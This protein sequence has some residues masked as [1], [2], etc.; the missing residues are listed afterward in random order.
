MM[1]KWS[2]LFILSI[3]V[4]GVTFT[5]TFFAVGFGVHTHTEK[6]ANISEIAFLLDVAE[7]LHNGDYN[8]AKRELCDLLLR[9]ACNVG[10][11]KKSHF[12]GEREAANRS[13]AR[14]GSFYESN[15]GYLDSYFIV[16]GQR[17]I[18]EAINELNE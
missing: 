16:D 18:K 6:Q 9:H 11:L 1:I 13:L 12:F 5:I 14:I 8:K 17:Y 3:L 7:P 15:G 10:R 2:T 4:S